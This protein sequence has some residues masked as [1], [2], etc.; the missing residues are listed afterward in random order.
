MYPY[1]YRNVC[2]KVWPWFIRTLWGHGRLYEQAS[3]S[4][5]IPV[6][7]RIATQVKRALNMF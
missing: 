1:W 6:I 2:L 5:I 4:V 7:E 3:N